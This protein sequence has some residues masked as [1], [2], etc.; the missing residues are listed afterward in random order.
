MGQKRDNA[1]MPTGSRQDQGRIA[2]HI[3]GVDPGS[4]AY[5][6]MDDVPIPV[7][8]VRSMRFLP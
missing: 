8:K 6:G 1:L 7:A 2:V 5:K 3:G 4:L